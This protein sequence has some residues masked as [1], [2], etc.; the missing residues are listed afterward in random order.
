MF[1]DS[2]IC[3]PAPHSRC[4]SHASCKPPQMLLRTVDPADA[5]SRSP[6]CSSAARVACA[7]GLLVVFAS[8]AGIARATLSEHMESLVQAHEQWRRAHPADG[9]LEHHR[10]PLP[11]ENRHHG[12]SRSSQRN[13]SHTLAAPESGPEAR[14][15]R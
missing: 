10:N 15:Q 8:F 4:R 13:Q 14:R 1:L 12:V 2:A 3:A 5:P 6:H 9:V 11:G 7:I